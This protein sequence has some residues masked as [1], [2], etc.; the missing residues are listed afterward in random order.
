MVAL[1]DGCIAL[2]IGLGLVLIPWLLLRV[3]RN[4][5]IRILYYEVVVVAHVKLQCLVCTLR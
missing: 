3:S 4:D 1:P 2:L 5:D